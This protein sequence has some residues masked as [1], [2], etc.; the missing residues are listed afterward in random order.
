MVADPG[1]QRGHTADRRVQRRKPAG[2]ARGDPSARADPIQFQVLDALE[3]R[4]SGHQGTLALLRQR[5]RERVDLGNGE[6]SLQ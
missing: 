5:R 3:L 4:I 6:A 1:V 2:D